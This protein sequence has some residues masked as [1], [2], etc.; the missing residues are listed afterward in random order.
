MLKQ[1]GQINLTSP[2]WAQTSERESALT[3]YVV[4]ACVEDGAWMVWKTSSAPVVAAGIAVVLWV[5]DSV[6][7]T[8]LSS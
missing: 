4:P 1:F 6:Q 3:G 7:I 2:G 5:L 8:R